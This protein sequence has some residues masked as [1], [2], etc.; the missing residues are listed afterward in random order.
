[1][2]GVSSL[3]DG[4][5]DAGDAGDAKR[6]RLHEPREADGNDAAAAALL[7]PSLLTW[8]E[9]QLERA[10]EE[11]RTRPQV[12]RAAVRGAYVAS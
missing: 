5:G 10:S 12:T 2:P 6:Q 11:V 1:M 9:A 4:A 8:V 3:E 7:P